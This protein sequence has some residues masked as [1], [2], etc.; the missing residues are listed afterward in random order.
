[1]CYNCGCGIKDDDMGHEE[2][3]TLTDMARASIVN[4]MSGEETLKNIKELLEITSAEELDKKI[5]ELKAKE[6]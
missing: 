2:N 6:Q 3:I 4:D 1:M 5:E